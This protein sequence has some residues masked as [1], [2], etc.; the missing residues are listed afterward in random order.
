MSIRA[1]QCSTCLEGA[2]YARCPGA[3]T[4]ARMALQERKT[5]ASSLDSDLRP[6]YKVRRG[7][8]GEIHIES[9]DHIVAEIVLP[10]RYALKVARFIVAACNGARGDA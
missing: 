2:P 8:R 3:K 7:M 9:E 6:P 10:D 1:Q 4:C 5:S